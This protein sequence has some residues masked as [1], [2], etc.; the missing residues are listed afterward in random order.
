M[1]IVMLQNM[2]IKVH[3][4]LDDKIAPGVGARKYLT[5]L[6]DI[7]FSIEM[8]TKQKLT[9]RMASSLFSKRAWSCE[10][11]STSNLQNK[12][13]LDKKVKKKKK[14]TSEEKASFRSSVRSKELR[15][16][17]QQAIPN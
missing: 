8:Q 5:T 13:Q 7:I 10:T 4:L 15:D 12:F 17:F 11:F 9:V 2:R 3:P 1:S 16:V 14:K 6:S